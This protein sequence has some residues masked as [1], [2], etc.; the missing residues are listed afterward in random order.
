MNDSRQFIK[1][2]TRGILRSLKRNAFFSSLTIVLVL[3]AGQPAMAQ[4]DGNPGEQDYPLLQRFAGSEIVSYRRAPD[5]TYRL[6]LGNMRRTAGRVVA[7]RSERLRGDL[8]RITYEIPAGFT[9]T[10]VIG[11]YQNQV[12]QN[13]YTELFS[14]SGRDCGNSNYW[15]NEVFDDRSL[16]GPERNQYYLA[17]QL[18]GD[19][20]PQVYAVMYVITRANRRLLVHI[21]VLETG[22]EESGHG[23]AVS[24]DALLQG[25]ALQIP[26]IRFDADD[27][28][29]ENG[30]LDDIASLLRENESIQVY[31]VAHLRAQ[32]A[33]EISMTRSARRA[34]RVRQ[35]L[36][37][38]GIDE[39]RLAAQ[40]VGPLA[41]LCSEGNCEER[42][43]LVVREQN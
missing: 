1:T 12:E 20:N 9:S 5:N 13:N 16:Y 14:C 31:I 8:T 34:E 10:D 11:F 17:L 18:E 43:E 6:V 23:A 32:E 37:N 42:V 19:G 2:A 38:Q 21:D 36:I 3:F 15:A 33:F 4:Q 35:A 26:G 22:G 28:L 41:P 27:R 7:E 24:S 25:G 40:G 30:G 29:V 39:G